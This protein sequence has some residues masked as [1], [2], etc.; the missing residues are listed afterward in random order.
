MKKNWKRIA[1][2][3]LCLVGFLLLLV[4]VNEF[5][6][7]PLIST[8]GQS[9]EKAIVTKIT[10]DNLAEDGNRY[11]TQEVWV[12][13]KTGQFAGQEFDAIN[14]NGS[15]FGADCEV[16]T[17]VIVIVSATGDNAVVTVYS[18]DRT[19]IIYLF[20]MFFALVVCLLGGKKGIKSVMSLVFAGICIIYLMFPLM[21]R[22][23]SPILITII[24]ALLTTIMTLGLL[25]GFSAKTA[26]A[27]VGTTSG[28][29][30]A[31]IAALVFGKAAGIT[32][33]NV[34]D[35]ETLSYVAQNSQIR[36]GQL[37]FAGI[38]ISALGA[39]MDVGMSIS[40]TI[41][42]LHERNPELGGKELFLSGIRVGR[43]MMGTMTNT[44]IFAYVGGALSTLVTNYAYDLS[45]NQLMNSYTIGIEIMQ[46]LSGSLGVVLTVPV[47]AAVAAI[48]IGGSAEKK[49]C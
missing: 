46:G 9:Y 7:T 21:Y 3:T 19:S 12:Q 15:L 20:A 49:S 33:Y 28:V 43:D 30:I 42:E 34:S 32:G 40:S 36:I 8:D 26:A 35:I 13:V 31:A 2:G 16:G 47:T 18:L 39:T 10:K 23:I 44:L 27:I 22:G 6:K 45:Y 29:V 24:V 4:K 5:E 41:Q 48:L 37:L 1:A 38:I 17:R 14:P 11:G 25:G